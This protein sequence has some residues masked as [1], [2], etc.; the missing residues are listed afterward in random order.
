MDASVWAKEFC[1]LN[2]GFDEGYAIT[3]FA[4]AIMCG[5]DTAARRLS[6]KL[7]EREHF[8]G[9]AMQGILS[10][11][12]DRKYESVAVDSVK[13][14]DALIAELAKEKK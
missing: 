3:W 5:Y 11:D 12:A 9:L 14:A 1:R 4:N 2:P 10:Y 13:Y 6:P 8:A 7:S